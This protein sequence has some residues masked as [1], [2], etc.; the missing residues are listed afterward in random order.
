[1][2]KPT[3][4]VRTLTT[5]NEWTWFESHRYEILKVMDSL[6]LNFNINPQNMQR[7]YGCK[8]KEVKTYHFSET[9]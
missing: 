6:C 9:A 8:N 1:M 3:I 5:P 4:L 7:Q 2:A